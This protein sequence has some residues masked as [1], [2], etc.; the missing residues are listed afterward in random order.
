MKHILLL[1][2]FVL[3][4]CQIKRQ[5]P[6]LVTPPQK[7]E[8]EFLYAERLPSILGVQKNRIVWPGNSNGP[9]TL[10]K[11]EI[12]ATSAGESVISRKNLG[13]FDSQNYF[14]DQDSLDDLVAKASE[15][16]ERR[17]R[18]SAEG[19]LFVEYSLKE[20]HETKT[21]LDGTKF[22]LEIV[23]DCYI[24]QSAE[25]D[26]ENPASCTR[27]FLKDGAT[28]RTGS[29]IQVSEIVS[30]GKAV[31]QF[32]P[33]DRDAKVFSLVTGRYQ[34][35]LEIRATVDCFIKAGRVEP[36]SSLL[37]SSILRQGGRVTHTQMALGANTYLFEGGRLIGQNLSGIFQSRGRIF[38]F[39]RTGVITTIGDQYNLSGD[40]AADSLPDLWLEVPRHIF[41][42]EDCRWNG[43][44]L[45]L[46]CLD[47]RGALFVGK[48]VGRLDISKT[49]LSERD[50]RAIE[51]FELVDE[52]DLKLQSV[53]LEAKVKYY[54]DLDFSQ[55]Q[56]DLVRLL[57]ERLGL[58]EH[59]LKKYD[60]RTVTFSCKK[61]NTMGKD[62]S[63]GF[64]IPAELKGA[65]SILFQDI[66]NLTKPE[67]QIPI[68]NKIF[69]D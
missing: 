68:F 47:S 58:V 33:Q 40:A 19:Q 37:P 6:V 69:R 32:V 12:L 42:F 26:E 16:F 21:A 38:H 7:F 53:G 52:L 22:R 13:N 15:N 62:S 20:L 9:V 57:Q 24:D 25:F 18:F 36:G 56:I 50:I 46:R 35:N 5:E 2:V 65:A 17:G 28:L 55:N 51:M 49:L 30:P 63:L 23:P 44:T 29:P 39:A 66:E 10:E 27:I 41:D 61:G 64:L 60:I 48:K 45:V 31:I 8:S 67:A 1:F 59:V 11:K 34:G 3:I 14:V 43:D 4:G 54:S